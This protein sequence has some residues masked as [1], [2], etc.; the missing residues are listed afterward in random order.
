MVVLTGFLANM[1][2]TT[3]S[4]GGSFF[5]SRALYEKEGAKNAIHTGEVLLNRVV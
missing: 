2:P 4:Q 1:S 5:T 3:S